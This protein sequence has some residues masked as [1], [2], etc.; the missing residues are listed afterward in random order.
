MK[1]TFQGLSSQQVEEN[2]NKFGSNELSPSE[3]ENFWDKLKGNFRDPIIIILCVALGIMTLFSFFG[4]TEWYEAVAIAIAV[5]LSTFVATFSE[6]KNE[7]SFQKLQEEAMR[8][9][10]NVFRDGQLLHLPIGE[11]VK[12]D[13]VLLQSGD[14]IP[15]DGIIMK[16]T[17]KVNE[18]SLTGE[19][20]SINKT[21]VDKDAFPE[22]SI[23]SQNWLFRGSVI[24]DGE[25][26]LN[27]RYVGDHTFYGELAKQ[28]T[29]DEDRLSPLQVK[30]KKLAQLIS[31]FG[32]IAASIIFVAF[33]L[34]KI[35]FQHHFNPELISA[36]FQSW[37]QFFVDIL[38]AGILAI[39]IVVAAVPEGLPMMIAIVLSLNMRKLLNE[40]VLV[41]KLLGIETAGSINILFTDKTGTITKGKFEPV[42]FLD[43]EVSKF[44]N[45]ESVP[46][47]LKELLRSSLLEN[48]SCVI[49]PDGKIEGGNQSGRA[50]LS[51]LNHENLINKSL[52]TEIVQTI[53]FNS[54][55]KFSAT[56]IKSEEPIPGFS[57]NDL[58]LIK[59]APELVLNNCQDYYKEDGTIATFNIKEFYN[60]LKEIT[61]DSIRLIAIA[62]SDQTLT[63]DEKIPEKC[64]LI[65]VIGIQDEIREESRQAVIEGKAAGI[66][67]VML[68]GDRKE[69]AVA[70]AHEIGLITSDD[71]VILSSEELERFTDEELKV[72]LP[73]LRVISRAL[74]TD[75]SR[76]VR[77]AKEMDMVVGMT[78][79]GVN[80]SAALM[81]SDVGIAMGSGTE[82]SKEASDIVIL[83]DNLVSIANGVR[84]GR[85]IFKSI[86]KF[87][88]FQL[89]VNVAAVT[90]AFL[91]P[92]FGFDFPLTIIQLLW[93][94]IIMDTLAAIAFGGEPALKRFM[95]EKPVKRDENILTKNMTS[96]VIVGG[97]YIAFFSIAFL[98]NDFFKTLF[99]RNGAFDQAV[100]VSAFFSLFV[101]LIT[102]NSFNARTEKMNILEN[103]F[104]NKRF[105]GVV[106]MIIGL[107][108]IFTY[109]G[110][111]ILRVKA[112]TL[113]EWGIITLLS[114]TIIPIDLFR[115]YIV[116]QLI[117]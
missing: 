55:R 15:A 65:G 25:V 41:R 78:G 9:S 81:Q 109:I 84:Y 106:G 86:R 68:T 88:V 1:Y 75:K 80:D 56:Q 67:I 12:E 57:K 45:F 46:D 79:D 60:Q 85:T 105:L 74:P 64:T 117:D 70:I 40:K 4:V 6:F 76:L 73:A 77:L 92:F 83:D 16:G 94:N 30:L 69:T 98:S 5:V 7:T 14:K 23:E 90:T 27:V 32:Y 95:K 20:E 36:Y 58:T 49:S 89:T 112:L 54:A 43:G 38:E 8:I 103:I 101:F 53:L 62:S 35:L 110:G 2:R 108:I 91:G 19:S 26:I 18:A 116:N 51:F 66:Q 113:E 87:I 104:K 37:E 3:I 17:A 114:L 52:K 97:L 63:E 93:I 42:F 34:N 28:L 29:S 61:N 10:A 72:V 13:V 33:M 11:I 100:F 24:D 48:T 82:V 115:K 44:N 71:D 111:T 102:I 50:V 99:F 96:S 47:K 31:K 107:Q 39:I 59:G 22:R 21:S